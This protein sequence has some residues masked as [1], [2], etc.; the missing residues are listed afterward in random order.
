MSGCTSLKQA[1]ELPAT[2]LEWLCYLGMFS[3]CTSLTHAPELPATTL[4]YDCYRDMFSGCTNLTQI[5]VS[6]DDWNGTSGWVSGVAPT[7]TFYCPKA[8][9]LEYGEDRIPEGWKFKS[10]VSQ[11]EK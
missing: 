10:E 5:S 1:P 8:L 7:G 3:G 6:F 9:P 2:T 4:D 11:V